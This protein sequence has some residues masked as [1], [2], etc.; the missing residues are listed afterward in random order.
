MINPAPIAD[1]YQAEGRK[2][3][4]AAFG[5]GLVPG[6]CSLLQARVKSSSNAA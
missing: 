5:E 2:A 3:T 1:P 4:C 6:E